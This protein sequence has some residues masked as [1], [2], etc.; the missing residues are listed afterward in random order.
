[1]ARSNGG[2]E[3]AWTLHARIAILEREIRVDWIERALF[4]SFDHVD[5]P[6][7]A[8]KRHAFVSIP[9]FGSRILHVVYYPNTQP[10]RVISDYFDRVQRERKL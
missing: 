10:I 7:D 8:D 3:L 4:D 9:E 5:D 1:M 6:L 2:R